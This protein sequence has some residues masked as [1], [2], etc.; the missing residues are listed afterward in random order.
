MQLIFLC[1]WII[2][3]IRLKDGMGYLLIGANEKRNRV[4][5]ALHVSLLLRSICAMLFIGIHFS[6]ECEIRM[7]FLT[8]DD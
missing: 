3:N 2:N 8:L 1:M 4:T 5:S 7:F 6:V